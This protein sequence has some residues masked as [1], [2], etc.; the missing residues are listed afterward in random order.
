[1]SCLVSQ[2]VILVVA[3]TSNGSVRVSQSVTLVIAKASTAKAIVSQDVTLV[4]KSNTQNNNNQPDV[5]IN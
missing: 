3:K 4:V 1:M 5:F 2:D